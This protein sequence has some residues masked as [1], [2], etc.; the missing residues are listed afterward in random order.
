MRTHEPVPRVSKCVYVFFGE[1]SCVCMLFHFKVFLLHSNPYVHT[2]TSWT[3]FCFHPLVAFIDTADVLLMWMC[4]QK[5]KI[6]TQWNSARYTKHVQKISQQF[7]SI[8]LANFEEA[9]RRQRRQ[10]KYAYT[11]IYSYCTCPFYKIQ[12]IYYEIND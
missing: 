8:R 10:R 1:C 6:Y 7:F 12:I 5:V 11:H 4:V 9:R 3:K 2:Y